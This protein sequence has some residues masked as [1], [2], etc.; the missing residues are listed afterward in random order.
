M[1]RR[2]LRRGVDVETFHVDV[3]PA[4]AHLAREAH[5]P[6]RSTGPAQVVQMPVYAALGEAG[7]RRRRPHGFGLC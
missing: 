6:A 2:A 5:T 1:V 4:V 3:W 7:A